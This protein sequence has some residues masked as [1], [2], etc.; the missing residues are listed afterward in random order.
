MPIKIKVVRETIAVPFVLDQLPNQAQRSAIS[1]IILAETALTTVESPSAI[2][3]ELNRIAAAHFRLIQTWKRVPAIPELLGGRR[4][5]IDQL[6][7]S[8][9]ISL[10]FAIRSIVVMKLPEVAGTRGTTSRLSGSLHRWQEQS[11]QNADDGED[12]EEFHE[13]NPAWRPNGRI[14]R[15]Q[16]GDPIGRRGQTFGNGHKKTRLGISTKPGSILKSGVQGWS[17]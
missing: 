15:K 8:N 3:H 4:A 6:D 10:K 14:R 11:D 5:D 1:S 7:G 12:D 17:R 16:H 9:L 2:L 13:R